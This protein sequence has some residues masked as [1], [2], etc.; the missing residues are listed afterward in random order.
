MFH[1]KPFKDAEVNPEP[2]SKDWQDY[3]ELTFRFLW[4]YR[5]SI[6]GSGL[7]AALVVWGY[8]LATKPK[9]LERPPS[10]TV[11]KKPAEEHRP[12]ANLDFEIAAPSEPD[13]TP[14]ADPAPDS[15]PE[16]DPL[17]HAD[18][19]PVTNAISK[20]PLSR[21]EKL[22]ASGTIDE[23]IEESLRIHESW[24]NTQPSVGL[25]MCVER[26]K[27][28]R[29]LLE[30]NLND[31]EQT[32]AVTSYIDSIGLIDSLNVLSKME[33]VGTRA[34]LLEIDEMYAGHPDPI[35]CA[36][37][38]LILTLA[39]L[40]DFIATGDVARLKEFR[41]QF[42][43][44][45]ELI[46]PDPLALTRL[47]DLIIGMRNKPGLPSERD[48]VIIESRNRLSELKSAS[49]QRVANDF[50]QRLLFDQFE[51][52]GMANLVLQDDPVNRQQVQ[53]FF[54]TLSQ[55][56]DS[57]LNIYQFAIDIISAHRRVGNVKDSDSLARWLE[58][59]ADGISKEADRKSVK[60][61]ISRVRTRVY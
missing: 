14:D 21:I 36:K 5:R 26:A 9:V 59:I 43:E 51:L 31:S 19:A 6:I 48:K 44:R 12:S 54:L 11:V 32:F 28:S 47:V 27:I 34:A 23:L 10:A 2:P 57:S 56:P 42:T 25:V 38:N 29:R 8:L 16:L 13:P 17:N 24:G 18:E 39:P 33:I 49:S 58:G 15:V 22:L 20:A 55:N 45:I 50:H 35:V 1:P 30:M 41:K 46:A 53:S 7:V 4:F 37:A 40:N 60:D 3:A 61:A 52:A